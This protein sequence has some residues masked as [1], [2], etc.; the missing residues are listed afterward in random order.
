M[1]ALYSIIY[2]L[3]LSVVLFGEYRKRPLHLRSRWLREKR[4]HVETAF[5]QDEP[6]VWIHAVS[7][8]EVLAAVPFVRA[9]RDRYPSLQ[10][11]VSTI[12]DTGQNIAMERFGAFARII[13]MPFDLPASLNRFLDTVRP[14]LFLIMETELWPNAIRI[15]HERGIR[16][17]L[18]N[19][20]ISDR[21]FRGYR[22]MRFFMQEV[23]RR[24]SALC[25]QNEVYAE[26]LRVLGA[27]ADTVFAA[28]NLKFD[29][30]IPGIR[31]VWTERLRGPVVIAGS[32]HHPE[33]EIVLSSYQK[34]RTAV[35]DLNLILAPRH[36]ERFG[37]V[38]TLLKK[39][40]V[41]YV[42]RTAAGQETTQLQGM[43]VLL[44]AMGELGIT[45][46]AADIA[47]MG[48]SFLP[49]GGQNLLE[50]AYWGKA[51]LCGPHMQNF[52]FVQEFCDAGAA[53]RVTAETLADELSSLLSSPE[54]MRTMGEAAHALL[55]QNAGATGRTL[56]RVTALLAR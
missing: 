41:R 32:T 47:V 44:D 46:A 14:Q 9:L 17:A 12:T 1:F 28:G 55:E 51:I 6:V 8:G 4:G 19:G 31:P 39:S 30:Q 21:S 20:R 15:C 54:T 43:V 10:I 49:H 53:R 52:P 16:V 22:K 2:L 18:I 48:G 42:R 11:A 24:M 27:S 37:E 23:F 35:P 26:R 7:V 56:D 29:L 40:G 34:V 45:Y 50:P 13:Y 33:E 3:A 36:P 25:M 38:E 5:G